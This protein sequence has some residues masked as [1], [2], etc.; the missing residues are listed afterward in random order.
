MLI[1]HSPIGLFVKQTVMGRAF[2]VMSCDWSVRVI[3]YQQLDVGDDRWG[4]KIFCK[5]K[6][7]LNGKGGEGEDEMREEMSPSDASKSLGQ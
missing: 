7:D 3:L 5:C 1:D 6:V 4:F 2:K